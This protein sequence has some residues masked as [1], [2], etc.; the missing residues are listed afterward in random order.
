[1]AET[2]KVLGSVT[3]T[4]ASVTFSNIP[5]SFT[6]I[7]VIGTHSTSTSPNSTSINMYANG[8]T[9]SNYNY[10]HVYA[11]WSG[12]YFIQ[13]NANNNKGLIGHQAASGSI[14]SGVRNYAFLDAYIAGYAGNK[15]KNCLYTNTIGTN[16]SSNY[17]SYFV[18]GG[19]M[20]KSTSPITSLTIST[21]DGS[22]FLADTVFTLYGILA[23]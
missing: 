14:L 12:N 10:N 6:D 18:K 9:G 8:D 15:F 2:Y 5:Q 11:Y 20:W 21:E 13:G 4:T 1:M 19:C 7:T 23:G 17:G 22:S 3:P 16:N